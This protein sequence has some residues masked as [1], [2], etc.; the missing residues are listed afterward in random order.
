MEPGV[1]DIFMPVS[2]PTCERCCFVQ[3]WLLNGRE[4]V[5]RI[6]LLLYTGMAQIPRTI[7]LYCAMHISGFALNP[8]RPIGLQLNG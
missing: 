5:C 4:F 1:L 6:R 3:Y 8:K 2:Q 7:D